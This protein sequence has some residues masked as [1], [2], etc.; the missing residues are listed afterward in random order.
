VTAVSNILSVLHHKE[1]SCCYT[2][3]SSVLTASA[4]YAN[5]DP[6]LEFYVLKIFCLFS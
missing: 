4:R 3:C 6:M 1:L 2:V 5:M